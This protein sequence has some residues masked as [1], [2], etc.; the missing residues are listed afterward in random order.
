MENTIKATDGE[1]WA[2]HANRESNTGIG[3]ARICVQG[4][5]DKSRGA[6]FRQGIE[7]G[8]DADEKK[9]VKDAGDDFKIVN[10]FS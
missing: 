6:S 8:N 10:Y 7:G 3:P 1:C 5:E 4:F 9:N 2:Q